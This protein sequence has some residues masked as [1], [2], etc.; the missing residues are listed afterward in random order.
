MQT[1]T[2]VTCHLTLGQLSF[3][4]HALGHSAFGDSPSVQEHSEHS[5]PHL[6]VPE[7]S[8][9]PHTATSSQRPC[10]LV[11]GPAWALPGPHL[12]PAALALP[13][14][15]PLTLTP[16]VNSV[17]KGVTPIYGGSLGGHSPPSLPQSFSSCRLK[18]GLCPP[19]PCP[20]LCRAGLAELAWTAAEPVVLQSKVWHGGAHACSSLTAPI[21]YSSNLSVQHTRGGSVACGPLSWP[22]MQRSDPRML[23]TPLGLFWDVLLVFPPSLEFSPAN[24]SSSN[25]T[26]SIKPP[27]PDGLP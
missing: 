26:Q 11:K 5:P 23:L 17:S 21:P 14:L 13:P 9:Y 3:V 16:L 24:H 15:Q 25:R 27:H 20:C 10:C 22:S 8:E 4:Q 12:Y 19:T 7:N 2:Q 6:H 18:P 1:A